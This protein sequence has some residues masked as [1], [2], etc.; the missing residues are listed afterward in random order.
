MGMV[1]SLLRRYASAKPIARY[2]E[3]TG[4][5]KVMSFKEERLGPADLDARGDRCMSTARRRRG[6]SFAVS[7]GFEEA[8]YS[9]VLA[10]NWRKAALVFSEQAAYDLQFSDERE[11]NAA[12]ALLRSARCY[13]QIEDKE[14]G[15]V[16]A[17][18]HA[19][20]KAVALL[21]KKNH[22]CLA[23]TGCVELAQFYM[24][25]QQLQ[26]ALDSYEQAAD[27]YGA[28]R[29]ANRYCRFKANMVRF[30]LA[31]EEML[32]V[33]GVLPIKD[34]KTRFIKSSDP[35][36]RTQVREL[37]MSTSVIQSWM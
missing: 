37:F 36:W 22:L 24:L 14:E 26:N 7:W 28:Y 19:L 16:A 5:Y 34:D 2:E 27:Y 3:G 17:T 20:E 9:Y 12:S 4:E 29:R 6:W 18:K 15:E 31:N 1:A 35:D 11:L 30:M 23:A 25:H 10:E 8:A 21:V 13:M 32:R 33:N